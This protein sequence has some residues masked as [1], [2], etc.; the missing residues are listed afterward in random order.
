MNDSILNTVK[1]LLGIPQDV[2]DFDND[3]IVYINTVFS[4]VNQMGIGPLK[5]YKIT[6]A[7]D[8]WSDFDNRLDMEDFKTYMYL[9]VKMLFDPPA[10]NQ[11]MESYNKVIQE[12]EFRIHSLWDM[13][14][15]STE[16]SIQNWVKENE[17][18]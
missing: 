1:K 5:C 12:L 4:M 17:N 2:D 11:I 13:Y 10:N 7:S 14:M 16:E 3:L 9:K 18:I 6:N 8:K 15:G